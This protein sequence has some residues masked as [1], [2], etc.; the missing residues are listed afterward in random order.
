MDLLY[1]GSDLVP[2]GHVKGIAAAHGNAG[3]VGLPELSKQLLFGRIVEGEPAADV[4]GDGIVAVLAA[5][6]AACHP[7]DDAQA[8]AV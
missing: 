2:V 6:A 1:E 3:D 7:Q 8:V 4:P 5:M